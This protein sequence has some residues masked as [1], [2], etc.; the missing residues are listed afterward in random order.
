MAAD[1][2]SVAILLITIGGLLLLGLATDYLGRKTN[3]PRVTLL[4]LFGFLLGPGALGL[5]PDHASEWMPVVT[6]IALLLVGFLLGGKLTRTNTLENGVVVLFVS[7]SVVLTTLLIVTA[8]LTLIGVPF[9]LALIF[10]AI[11]TA[12]DPAATMDVINE[13]RAQGKFTDTLQGIVSIDDAWG[14]IVFSLVLAAVQM[15][16]GAEGPL[17]VIGEAL[18]ELAGATGLGIIPGLPMAYISGRI[19][20]GQPTLLEALG[21]VLLCGSL[22]LHLEVSYLLSSMVLGIVVTNLAKHHE[23]P[24]HEIEDIEWPFMVLFFT[25]TGASLAIDTLAQAG[26]LAVAY[27]V[28]RSAARYLGCWPGAQLAGAGHSVKYWMGGALLPQAGVAIGMALVAAA[29]FPELADTIILV[30]VVTTL[31]FELIGPICTRISL[32]KSGDIPTRV[33][34]A[35]FE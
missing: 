13:H 10:G 19:K 14:L 31:F 26:I 25:L 7:V 32:R 22:A 15:F 24:F 16:M 18:W 35:T 1:G 17:V 5:L 27:I 21:M 20:P 6:T 28:L 3:L 29:R 8:G 12:T 4:F 11:A 2:N 30:V 9:P 34:H 33:S 23:R